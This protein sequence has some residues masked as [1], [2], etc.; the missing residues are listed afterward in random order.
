MCTLRGIRPRLACLSR[1]SVCRLAAERRSL[2]FTNV[3]SGGEKALG[4]RSH[5]ALRDSLQN[6]AQNARWDWFHG[7]HAVMRNLSKC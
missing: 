1:Q 3:V 7:W 6:P 5:T 2:P 4:L